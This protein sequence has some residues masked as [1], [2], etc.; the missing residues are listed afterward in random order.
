MPS[1]LLLKERR[2]PDA[3]GPHVRAAQPGPEY[4]D[5]F[6]AIYPT[7]PRNMSAALSFLPGQV[8]LDPK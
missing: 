8:A 6:N 1:L 4:G 5:R 2:I 3:A 7:L